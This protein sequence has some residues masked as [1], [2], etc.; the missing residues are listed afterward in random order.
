MPFGLLVLNMN[1]F[2]NESNGIASLVFQAGTAEN[3]RLTDYVE[4]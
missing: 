2:D 3:L 4:S 1:E